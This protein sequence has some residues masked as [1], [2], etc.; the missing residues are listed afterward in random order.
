MNTCTSFHLQLRKLPDPSIKKIYQ[1]KILYS[2]WQRWICSRSMRNS[3]ITFL[4]KRVQA[5]KVQH[6]IRERRWSKLITGNYQNVTR[7]NHRGVLETDSRIKRS[8]YSANMKKNI[9]YYINYCEICQTAKYDRNSTNQKLETT[10]AP[11]RRPRVSLKSSF[12]NRNCQKCYNIYDLLWFTRY[13][14]HGQNYR[15]QKHSNPRRFN[16]SK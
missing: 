14:S 11:S 10:H 16:M 8:Y 3:N 12:W 9:S 6:P 5:F 13:Y 7:T 1:P 15:T 2:F 4:K